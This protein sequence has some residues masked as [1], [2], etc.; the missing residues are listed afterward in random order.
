MSTIM[1]NLTF[2]ILYHE[3]II[4][5]ENLQY[6]DNEYIYEMI[7]RAIQ[8]VLK[9]QHFKKEYDIKELNEIILIVFNWLFIQKFYEKHMSF[10]NH[11]LNYIK[12]E[13]YSFE[14]DIYKTKY[15]KLK[16]SFWQKWSLLRNI[17]PECWRSFSWEN[18]TNIPLYDLKKDLYFNVQNYL[19][20]FNSVLKKQKINDGVY[21]IYVE[22]DRPLLLE[23]WL[24]C[25]M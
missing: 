3:A 20:I 7:N 25:I 13:N 19:E 24:N 10:F 17:F 21:H 5:Y 9:Y 6:I 22:K 8:I 14:N 16:N 2:E 12:T 4:Y 1:N 11:Y 18:N 23:D 15:N